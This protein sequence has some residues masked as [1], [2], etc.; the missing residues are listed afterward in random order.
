MFQILKDKAKDQIIRYVCAGLTTT[1]LCWGSLFVFVEVIHLHYMVAANLSGGMAY[2]YSYIIN[3]YIVFKNYKREH[4]KQ[5]IAFVIVQFVIWV[6]ANVGLYLGV[7][8]IGLHYFLMVIVIAVFAA[9]LNFI[10]MKL[11]VF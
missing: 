4:I 3:K 6:C 8:V 2:V 1:V 9:L 5:G 11:F 10:L 7:T